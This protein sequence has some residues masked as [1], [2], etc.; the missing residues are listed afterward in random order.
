MEFVLAGFLHLNMKNLTFKQLK[1]SNTKRCEKHFHPINEWSE[2]DW[3]CALAGEIGELCNFIK[4]RKRARDSANHFGVMS[5]PKLPH[6]ED[7]KKE[8][9]DIAMYLDL[10]ATR[11]GLNLEDCVREKF[12]EVSGRV[13]NCKIKL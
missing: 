11:L 8:I 5:N 6:L 13:N 1:K 10:I 7:C 2:T 12:N 4:K 9:G 3:A